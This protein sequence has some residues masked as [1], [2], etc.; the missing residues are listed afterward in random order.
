MKKNMN[1]Q[2]RKIVYRCW[3]RGTREMDLILG[4]FVDHF[5]LELSSV[6][7]TMLESIIEE[8]DSNLFKW[9]TGMEKPPEYLR[10]PIFK[11]I[12]D[13]YSNNL[14]RKNMLGSLQ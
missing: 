4:S 6:E 1:L 2:C 9:F 12:Y 11:K 7:L 10:T 5:I 8:D 3:R 14:D 13:Y